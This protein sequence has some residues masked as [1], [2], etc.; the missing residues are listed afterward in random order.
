MKALMMKREKILLPYM[1]NIYYV[2]QKTE[3]KTNALPHISASIVLPESSR[4]Q[5]DRY[6]F[7]GGL[8]F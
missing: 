4:V 6:L 7:I 1:R 5:V 8:L 2:S 3:L